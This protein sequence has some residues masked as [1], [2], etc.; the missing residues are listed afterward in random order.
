MGNVRKNSSRWSE[1]EKSE[2]SRRVYPLWKLK[3]GAGLRHGINRCSALIPIICCIFAS[4]ASAQSYPKGEV[5][6]P[7]DEWDSVAAELRVDPHRGGT[8]FGRTY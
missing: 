1:T 4:Y 5:T 7:L 3:A 6:I 2:C 8:N